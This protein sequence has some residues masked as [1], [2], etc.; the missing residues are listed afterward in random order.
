MGRSNLRVDFGCSRGW[1]VKN[2]G[3]GNVQCKKVGGYMGNYGGGA[4]ERELGG[5]GGNWRGRLEEGK[6]GHYH[7]D[8]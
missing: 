4:V 1:G 2:L 3:E 5:I 7:Y 8:S 6:A